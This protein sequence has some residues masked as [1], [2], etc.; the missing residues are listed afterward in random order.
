MRQISHGS[1]P[2]SCGRRATSSKP[3]HLSTTWGSSFLA[4]RGSLSPIS[5]VVPGRVTR[6]FFFFI[7]LFLHFEM[8]NRI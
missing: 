1:L 4:F 5:I 3:L 8:S 2:S 7:F 6:S